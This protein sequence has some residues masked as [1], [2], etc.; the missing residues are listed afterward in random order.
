MTSIEGETPRTP[1]SRGPILGRFLRES[2]LSGASF[3]AFGALCAVVRGFVSSLMGTLLI[4]LGGAVA[5]TVGVGA[6]WLVCGRVRRYSIGRCIGAGVLAS[7]LCNPVL[8]T[9]MIAVQL[10]GFRMEHLDILIPYALM[11]LV[12]GW[13]TLPV[14]IAASLIAR[15][16]VLGRLRRRWQEGDPCKR[17][18]DSSEPGGFNFSDL[19]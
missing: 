16:L 13:F 5:G 18:W 4:T 14:G 17:G 7:L 10:H 8:P 12:V 6:W 19:D 15:K 9:A 1:P 3:A 11:Y 2:L